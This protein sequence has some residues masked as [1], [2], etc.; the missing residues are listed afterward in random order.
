MSSVTTSGRFAGT[1][2]CDL[3]ME[4]IEISL[5]GELAQYYNIVDLAYCS[6]IGCKAGAKTAKGRHNRLG[7]PNRSFNYKAGSKVL[8]MLKK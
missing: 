6:S 5:T 3:P 1:T 7:K 4:T 8:I 2:G